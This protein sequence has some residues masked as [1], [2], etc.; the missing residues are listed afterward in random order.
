MIFRLKIL[1]FYGQSLISHILQM[2]TISY[3]F[4]VIKYFPLISKEYCVG[5][6]M[7]V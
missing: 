6:K 5:K 3:Y 2:V 4:L 1:K 7:L